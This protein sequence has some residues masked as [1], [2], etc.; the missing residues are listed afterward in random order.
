MS[1]MELLDALE[2]K[3]LMKQK[4]KQYCGTPCIMV[5]NTKLS[6]AKNSFCFRTSDQWNKI[7]T[8]IRNSVKIN[9]FKKKLK[10]WILIIIEQF[11]DP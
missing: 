8:S 9:I 4:W 11:L 1:K 6:L 5:E 3:K 10:D 7:P 2:A